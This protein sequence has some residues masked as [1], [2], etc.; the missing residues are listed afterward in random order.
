MHP[1]R[2]LP[3]AGAPY[4][5]FFNLYQSFQD[6]CRRHR[7]VD[8]AATLHNHTRLPTERTISRGLVISAFH[9]LYDDGI[10]TAALRLARELNLP[11]CASQPA[12]GFYL[13]VVEDR[14]TLCR[15]GEAHAQGVHV[16][17]LSADI[18]RRAAAGKRAALARAL[19]LHRSGAT[20][21]LDTTCG[22]GRDSAVLAALGCTVT[23]IERHP[24]LHAL[25][26]DGLRRLDLEPPGWWR[27][28]WQALHNVDAVDWLA[29]KHSTTPAYDAIYID[30]MFDSPRRKAR[31]QRA[32]HWLHELIGPD[33]DAI[34]V[35]ELARA[36]AR[37]VVVKSHA[38]AAPLA[39]PDHQISGK[40]MRF[41]VYFNAAN[42]LR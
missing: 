10:D 2:C 22:L 19:G 6:I 36:R 12:T 23:A 29:G 39:P 40:A 9:G 11:R 32:L 21:V 28:R 15:A 16:D 31:P 5:S 42:D 38:R 33:T 8:C 27:G 41:D 13:A 4:S 17:L 30:P 18:H 37:R 20:H 14:L 24:A 26:A 34:A 3:L 7:I 25:L 1:V 35:L